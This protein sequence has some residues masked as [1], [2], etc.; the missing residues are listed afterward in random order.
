MGLAALLGAIPGLGSLNSKQ[1]TTNP[2]VLSQTIGNNPLLNLKIKEM[3][4]S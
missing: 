2:S 4:T 3:Q 1:V